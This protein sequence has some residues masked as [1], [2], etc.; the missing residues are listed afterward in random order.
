MLEVHIPAEQPLAPQAVA[1]SLQQARAWFGQKEY[2][3]F[4]CH[5]WLLAPALRGLLPAGANLLR[6]Q[7]LFTVYDV[8]MTCRQAEERVFGA[9]LDDPSAYP[10]N[11][12][13]QR[14]L[15]DYLQQGGCVGVGIGCRPLNA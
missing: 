1:D 4:H 12:R 14:S 6:F 5:S 2:A 3:L 13:L 10:G 8:D 15:R 7:D 9:L 11:T